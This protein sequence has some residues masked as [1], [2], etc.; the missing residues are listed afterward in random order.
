MVEITLNIPGA[1]TGTVD[2]IFS[3]IYAELQVAFPGASRRVE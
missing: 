2:A 3:E 1:P